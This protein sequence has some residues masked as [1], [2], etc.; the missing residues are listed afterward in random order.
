[1]N[2]YR[3]LGIAICIGGVIGSL[4]EIAWSQTAVP[5][6][7]AGLSAAQGFL[8][9]G[10]LPIAGSI[11]S[12]LALAIFGRFCAYLHTKWG[13]EVS[14]QQQQQFADIVGQGVAAA[15]EKGAAA[16]KTNSKLSGPMKYDSALKFIQQQA[17]AAGL[18][19]KII[20][21]AGEAI[22]AALAV[23]P[24]VG[25]TG[26]AIGTDTVPELARLRAELV[27][28]TQQLVAVGQMLQPSGA[29]H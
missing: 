16:I 19:K 7:T 10:I 23:T 13:I 6:A 21:G 26:D 28:K 11:A 29:Q 4:S 24:G 20:D 15:E 3:R 14:T 25:A 1:M 2:I 8:I 9:N 18:P 12:A 5:V 27:T 17:N 22:H